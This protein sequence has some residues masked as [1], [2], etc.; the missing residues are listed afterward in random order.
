MKHLPAN[1]EHL[2]DCTCHQ[3]PGA[4][5]FRACCFLC[6]CGNNIKVECRNTHKLTCGAKKDPHPKYTGPRMPPGMLIDGYHGVD[7]DDGC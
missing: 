6:E 2:C 1:T 7:D 5:H 3:P 4:L